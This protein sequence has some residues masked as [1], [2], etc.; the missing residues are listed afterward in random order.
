TPNHIS[1]HAGEAMI[2]HPYLDRGGRSMPRRFATP[3][4]RQSAKRSHDERLL[5]SKL[6]L[7]SQVFTWSSRHSQG[8]SSQWMTWAVGALGTAMATSKSS[9]WIASVSARS[10]SF[11]KG[12]W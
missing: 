5:R 9:P 4:R 6:P 1:H 11:Q 8:S 3:S 12:N 2:S 10:Y 7:Q